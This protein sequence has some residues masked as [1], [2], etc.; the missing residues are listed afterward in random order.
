M[1]FRFEAKQVDKPLRF[2]SKRNKLRFASN[3]NEQYT[4]GPIDIYILESKRLR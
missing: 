3:E 1:R 2:L 4:L